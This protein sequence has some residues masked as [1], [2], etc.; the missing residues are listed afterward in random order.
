MKKSSQ[1]YLALTLIGVILIGL[2]CG[3]SIFEISN[4]KTAD[5]RTNFS[6]AALPMV[7]MTTETLEAPLSGSGQFKLITIPGTTAIMTYKLTTVCKIRCWYKSQ[8]PKACTATT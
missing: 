7:E 1:I 3:I 4:Y 6:D 2:G 5:Y 8:D